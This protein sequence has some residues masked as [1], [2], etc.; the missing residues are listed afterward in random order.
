[1]GCFRETSVSSS[2]YLSLEKFKIVKIVFLSLNIADFPFPVYKLSKHKDKELDEKLLVQLDKKGAD[3]NL[4]RIYHSS[5]QC[6][7]HYLIGSSPCKCVSHQKAWLFDR[8][9]ATFFLC[10][11][12]PVSHF[13]GI[14]FCSSRC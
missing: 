3:S 4:Q 12:T 13:Y 11:I 9:T 8:A 1:M 10:C 14:M 5:N 2:Y 7:A 6:V